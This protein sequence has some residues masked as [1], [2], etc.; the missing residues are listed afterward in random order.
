[1]RVTV[2]ITQIRLDTTRFKREL[3]NN[4]RNLARS[5]ARAWLTRAVPAVP[6][7]S[8][9]AR[10]SLLKIARLSSGKV[11]ISGFKAPNRVPEGQRLGRAQLSAKGFTIETAVAHYADQDENQGVSASSPWKSFQ[12]GN[13]A[14][15]QHIRRTIAVP[16][17]KVI[18]K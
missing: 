1:M 7:Y 16:K 11:S 5:A 14:A 10:G 15:V 6:V 2:T 9:M 4:L 18:R 3:E 13:R 17:V 12:L 8:G